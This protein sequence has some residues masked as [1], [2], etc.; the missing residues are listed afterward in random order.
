MGDWP[1]QA[2]PTP[3]IICPGSQSMLAEFHTGYG[4][5]TTVVWPAANLAIFLPFTIGVITTFV[6]LFYSATASSGNVDMG[7]Y[8]D[9]GN[10][11]VSMGSTAMALTNLTQ[12]LDITDTTLLPGSYYLAMACSTNVTATFRAW[13][14]QGAGSNTAA[15]GQYEMATA[16]PLPATA[17]FASTT[18][19]FMPFIAASQRTTI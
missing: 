12:I 8:D 9:Q 11:L 18:R 19:P 16:L 7:I 17:T 6:K 10:R 13:V 14:W 15:R 5:A 1:Q 3:P 4:S 2:D